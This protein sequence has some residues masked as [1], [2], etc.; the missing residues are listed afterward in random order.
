[1]LQRGCHIF[2]FVSRP[3]PT[4]EGGKYGERN[5]RHLSHPDDNDAINMQRHVSDFSVFGRMSVHM[6]VSANGESALTSTYW[7]TWPFYLNDEVDYCTLLVCEKNH[8]CAYD[9][10]HPAVN[11]CTWCDCLWGVC[12]ECVWSVRWYGGGCCQEKLTGDDKWR[13]S[14]THWAGNGVWAAGSPWHKTQLP[15][16]SLP[17]SP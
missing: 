10:P 7:M 17:S 6:F 15:R 16:T 5:G 12:V 4:V 11:I 14:E 9:N 1:M 8:T 13:E 3:D 2:A